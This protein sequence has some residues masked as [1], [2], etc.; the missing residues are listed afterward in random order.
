[1]TE[2]QG[3]CGFIVA[4]VRFGQCL[5][6]TERS[7][8]GLCRLTRLTKAMQR[9]PEFGQQHGINEPIPDVRRFGT[10]I[11][12]VQLHRVLEGFRGRPELLPLIHYVGNLAVV[13][14]LHPPVVAPSGFSRASRSAMRRAWSKNW[15]A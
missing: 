8:Q 1:M 5:Q 12:F 11:L 14:C 7:R 2:S 3:V 9:P 10:E 13:R 6:N 4:R 15:S